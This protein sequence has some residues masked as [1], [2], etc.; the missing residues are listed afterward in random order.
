MTE[1]NK[2]TKELGCPKCKDEINYLN[3]DVTATCGSSLYIGD[4]EGDYDLSCLTDGVEYNN[5]RCPECDEVLFETEYEAI[6]F[7]DGSN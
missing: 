6:K 5:F 1:K 2:K 3:F 4:K 7:L